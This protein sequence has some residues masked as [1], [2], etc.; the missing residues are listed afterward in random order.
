MLGQHSITVS[1][2]SRPGNRRGTTVGHGEQI[3]PE[4]C[5]A[6]LAAHVSRAR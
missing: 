2:A 4:M 5:D 1:G 6:T 3:R